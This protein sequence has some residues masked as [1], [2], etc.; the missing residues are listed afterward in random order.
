MIRRAIAVV[1]A[2]LAVAPAATAQTPGRLRW[3]VGQVL[4]YRVEHTTQDNEVTPDAAVERKTHL[5]LVK[6][7]QVVEVD[8]D[9][10]ATVR[11]WLRSLVW[12]TTKPGGDVLRFD[13][14]DPDKST[15]E[16]RNSFAKY[17]KEPLAVLRIDPLG[18]VVQVKESRYGPAS[19]FEI[20]LPFAAVLPEGGLGAGKAWERAFQITLEPPQGT[21]EKYA[22]VQRYA[23]KNVADNLATVSLTT[24]LKTPPEAA[25]DLMP[26]LD[27]MPEGEVVFD[28]ASGRMVKATL[29]IEKEL[30]GHMGEK[31]TYKLQSN[32]VEQYVGDR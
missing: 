10:V 25:A 27:K 32:Y 24:A 19:R 30:K 1:L 9:G 8:R 4:T 18:R 28:Q 14:T 6:S 15:P 16:M 3:Q 29:H 21:G 22:A 12:E 20:E 7:W 23:C 11:L 17:F 5:N 31:S 26:L 13:S 2:A